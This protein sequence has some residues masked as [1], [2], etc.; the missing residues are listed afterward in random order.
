MF[1]AYPISFPKSDL[2]LVLRFK[3]LQK[4]CQQNGFSYSTRNL[5]SQIMIQIFICDFVHSTGQ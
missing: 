5:N 4:L 1:S 2:I 3:K